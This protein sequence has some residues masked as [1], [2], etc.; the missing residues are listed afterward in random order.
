ME[1][2]VHNSQLNRTLPA[3]AWNGRATIPAVEGVAA[4]QREDSET[5]IPYRTGDVIGQYTLTKYLCGRARCRLFLGEDR[6]QE[7]VVVKL[8]EP[9]SAKST[10]AM[11]KLSDR[12]RRKGC[13]SLMPLLSYGDLEGEIHYEVMP[14]YQQGTLEDTVL[15]EQDLIRHILP[16]LNSAL[17]FLGENHLVHND[18]KPSNLFWKDRSRME[19][20]L[21]DYDCLTTDKDETAGGTPFFM[22]PER[23]YSNNS[24][25]TNASDYC[26]MGLTLISLLLGKPLLSEAEG[27]TIEEGD[28]GLLRRFLYRRWQQPVNCPLSVSVSPKFRTLLNCMVLFDPNERM[29]YCGEYITK[30]IEGG[31]IAGGTYVRSGDRKRINGL[32]YRD[33]L[34]LD[35]PEL[36]AE[37]GKNWDYAVFMLKEHQLDDFVR[38]FDGRFYTYCLQ[39]AK[40]QN[41]SAGLFKLMQSIAPSTD[42]YWMGEHYE[43]MEEFVDRTDEDQRYSLRDPFSLFCRARLLSFYLQQGGASQEQ[44]K[45]ASEIE[46]IG[47]TEPELAVRKLQ[48]SLQQ[49][50]DFKWHG[51]AFMSLEEVLAWLEG[52]GDKLDEEAAGLY[53]SKAFR[54]WL[55]YIGHGS[56]LSTVDKEM[57]ERGI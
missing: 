2:A 25:H 43:S 21:G 56:F 45:R 15:S 52:C 38:Q 11:R 7:R 54:V 26:S 27:K 24:L 4:G 3:G 35:I 29:K 28:P 14:V 19:I 34:I 42:L 47:K 49:K 41:L 39:F 20:V 33:K 22:A 46:E 51:T 9:G 53:A 31:G 37:L 12:L 44:I 16:Q 5:G 40:M 57:M 32:R 23:I 13:A 17:L 10:M 1:T 48:I 8:Y 55:D 50:P 6:R 30:W 36:I 18:I